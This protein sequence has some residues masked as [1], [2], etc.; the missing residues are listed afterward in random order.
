LWCFRPSNTAGCRY[1]ITLFRAEAAVPA[2]AHLRVLGPQRKRE[3]CEARLAA[4]AARER[5]FVRPPMVGVVH[6][7]INSEASGVPKLTVEPREIVD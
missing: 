6:L 2:T 5:K 4:G 7:G 1:S 3:A